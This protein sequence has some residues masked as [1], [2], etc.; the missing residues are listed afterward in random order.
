MK[1]AAAAIAATMPITPHST[2]ANTSDPNK[3][4]DVVVR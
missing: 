3:K 4:L 1:N 2:I